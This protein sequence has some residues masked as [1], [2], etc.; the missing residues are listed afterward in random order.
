[1]FDPDQDRSSDRSDQLKCCL[2]QILEKN[3]YMLILWC[4]GSAVAHW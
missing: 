2:Y 3:K 1:M 4:V